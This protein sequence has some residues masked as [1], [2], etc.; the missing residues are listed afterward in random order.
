M[1]N[2]TRALLAMA[3]LAFVACGPSNPGTDAGTDSGPGSDTPMGTD[4]PRDAGTDN[5]SFDGAQ[6]VTIG[7]PVMEAIEAPGD[8][9]FWRFEGTAGDWIAINTTANAADDPTKIDT[10]ITLYDSTRTQIAENDD[11]VP[12]ANTDSE[13]IIHLP[14]TGTYYIE[15]QEF[16]DWMPDSPPAP[17]GMPSYTYQLA[18]GMVGGTVVNLDTETGDDAASAQTVTLGGMMNNLFFPMGTFEDA[19]DVDV[20]AFTVPAGAMFQLLSTD[21]MPSGATGYGSTRAAGRIYVTDTAGTEVIARV[22]PR[23]MAQDDLSPSLTAGDYLLWVD[24]GGGTAGANDFYVLKA[25][26][27]TENTPEAEAPGDSTNDVSAMAETVMITDDMGTGRAFFL[28]TLSTTDVDFYS[29]TS[30]TGIEA[31]VVCGSQSSGSGLTGVRV[32]LFAMDGTTALGSATETASEAAVIQDIPITMAGT[33]FVR[34]SA[35]GE[36][37]EVTSRFARCGVALAPPAP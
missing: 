21:I 23:D 9:D 17:E 6:A 4:A 34:L 11:A 29:F 5:G 37:P 13:I 30:P 22:Q 16:S 8:H 25:L 31:T 15:V 19:T 28:S 10:V 24:A 7:T 1:T 35:T 3:S 26:I 33:Y 36:S 20:Y 2:S 14:T 27:G 18:V 32:E 12:R